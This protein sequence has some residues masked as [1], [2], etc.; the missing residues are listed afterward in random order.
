[1]KE[2]I[3][4]KLKDKFYEIDWISNCVKMKA[5]TEKE[6]FKINIEGKTPFNLTT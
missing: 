2:D 3:Y 4:E 6:K 5:I 1:M